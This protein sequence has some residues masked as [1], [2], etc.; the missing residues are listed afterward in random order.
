MA[1]KDATRNAIGCSQAARGSL[2]GIARAPRVVIEA[3]RPV[4]ES[5]L[6]LRKAVHRLTRPVDELDREAL[7]RY[8]DA[9]G[10]TPMS[11][12]TP[13]HPA[14]VA[15][16]VRS[17]RIVPRAGADALEVNVSDGRDSVVAVF[18]GRRKI[19]GMSPGR[20]VLL[21]A[22]AGRDGNRFIL[23]NPEYELLS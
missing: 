19:A 17:V 18:L 6:P 10:V 21:S 11:Q 1:G 7:E 15:G 22:V 16:V 4:K 12:I 14:R 9:L 20:R 8:C 23:Y 3:K 13:R 5:R 2:A